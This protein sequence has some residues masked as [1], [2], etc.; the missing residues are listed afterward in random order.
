MKLSEYIGDIQSLIDVYGDLE[1]VEENRLY[2]QQRQVICRSVRSPRLRQIAVVRGGGMRNAEIHVTVANG[3]GE[4]AE[5]RAE[6][7]GERV[8]VI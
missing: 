4:A 1:I 8:F 6:L 5:H 7:T 3:G 2:P